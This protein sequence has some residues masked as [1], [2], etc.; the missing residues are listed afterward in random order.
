[1]NPSEALASGRAAFDRAASSEAHAL[2]ASADKYVALEPDDGR[3]LLDDGRVL[4]VA[5]VL[6]CTGFYTGFSWIDL[7]VFGPDGE[8]HHDRSVVSSQ[9]GL[10]FLGL[11]FLY[12]RSST[13][14]HGVGR[15]AA[16]IAE[17]V[18]AQGHSGATRG[19]PQP[20]RVCGQSRRDAR[21]ACNRRIFLGVPAPSWSLIKANLQLDLT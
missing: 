17:A 4:D 14:I 7:P 6:W 19:P 18:A 2:P 10:Y 15:D 16:R 20:E 3:P 8:P 12:A 1:M 9:P 5:N 13:M 11:H 21:C